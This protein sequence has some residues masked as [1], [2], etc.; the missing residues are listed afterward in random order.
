MKLNKTIVFL[1]VLVALLL[2]ACGQTVSEIQTAIMGTVVAGTQT[3]VRRTEVQIARQTIEP[4]QLPEL[5][6]QLAPSCDSVS[7]SNY[8]VVIG[9]F[10]WLDSNGNSLQDSDEPGI[11]GIPVDLWG[12][13]I[14]ASQKLGSTVTD[15]SGHF[16]FCI[17]EPLAP[18]AVGS[19]DPMFHF[20]LHFYAPEGYVWVNA[21]EGSGAN[22]DIDSKVHDGDDQSIGDSD[23]GG[24]PFYLHGW[25][26]DG[27][28]FF[29]QALTG[30]LLTM[31][32][33]LRKEEST[34]GSHSG[35]V[36]VT[37]TVDTFCRSGPGAEYKALTTITIGEKVQV[38]AVYSGSEYVVVRRADGSE[39]WL[40]LRYAEPSDFS[41]I[42]LPEADPPP[43]PTATNTPRPPRKPTPTPTF[44]IN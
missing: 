28:G 37:V 35:N 7:L 27:D 42:G 17:M 16:Y 40:W 14:W 18:D 24:L 1:L 2:Q 3:A 36:F 43:P 10:V 44:E 15:S 39:C 13:G 29:P 9:D 4:Q 26:N 31:D 19:N 25:T 41:G 20:R 8:R 12:V 21:Y 32:G 34:E 5:Q 33:G 22:N 38:V 11:P 23:E 6:A 30:F